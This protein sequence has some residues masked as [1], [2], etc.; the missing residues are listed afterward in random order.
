[1]P[2]AP[3]G[4]GPGVEVTHLARVP[5]AGG[6]VWSAA[7]AGCHV[8]LVVLDPGQSV[9]RHRNDAVDVQIVVTA[10]GGTAHVDAEAI[11]LEA[12]VAL[13]VPRG[14]MRSITAGEAGLRYLTV[15]AERPPLAI[16][17]TQG[18]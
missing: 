3:D 6:V 10:G 7:P 15:H 12:L 2:D 18:E 13:T 9:A 16:R 11:D 4:P 5:G 14:A 8:N 17:P 1:M